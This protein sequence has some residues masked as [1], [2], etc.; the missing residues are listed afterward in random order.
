[1]SVNQKAT[2]KCKNSKNKA[3]AAQVFFLFSATDKGMIRY[4]RGLFNRLRRMMSSSPAQRRSPP[5][6]VICIPDRA[7]RADVPAAMTAL[8]AALGVY[9]NRLIALELIDPAPAPFCAGAAMGA[10]IVINHRIP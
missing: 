1:M 6:P 8:Y 3:C 2:G 10:N 5:R 7:L 9:H 4:L